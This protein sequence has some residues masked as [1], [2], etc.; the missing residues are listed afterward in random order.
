MNNFLKSAELTKNPFPPAAT[1]M[2]GALEI[3]KNIYLP[4]EQSQ[5]ITD[6]YSQASHGSGVKVFPIIGAYGAGKSAV[7]KGYMQT[8]F[9]SKNIKVF[10]FDNPGVEFYSLAESM[11]RAL[12]RYEF[13]KGLFELCKQ[14]IKRNSLFE[15]TFEDI[16]AD[17]YNQH[18]Q[19]NFINELGTIVLNNLKLTNDEEIAHKLACIVVD[20]YRKRYFERKDFMPSNVK[21]VVSESHEDKFFHAI[22]SSIIKIYNVDGVAFLIDEFEEITF[23]KGMTKSKTYE[24]LSTFRRLIDLSE[25]VSL[26]VVVAMTPEALEQTKAMNNALVA[27]FVDIKIK[28]ELNPFAE[29][30]IVNW[31]KWWL[32]T[33]RIPDSR[34]ND[35]I[36]PFPAEFAQ[37]MAEHVDRCYPRKL[38]KT[39]FA[40]LADAEENNLKVPLSSDYTSQMIKQLFEDG[41]NYGR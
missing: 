26:W 6:F 7:L 8:F 23:S 31:L 11:M 35:T 17:V 15:I 3:Y 28:I 24:Y 5:A 16:L 19:N 41:T 33:A 2:G 18:D 4:P 14:Y 30:N 27:R 37:Q 10:Y 25:K 38:V 12:G 29:G 34:Y 21:S 39:C 32:N 40:I 36:F 1:G 9:E 20:T 22:I 13:S